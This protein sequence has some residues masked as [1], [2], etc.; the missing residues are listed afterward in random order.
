MASGIKRANR[1][2]EFT[3]EQI[4]EL[5]KCQKDPV[6]FIR[7]YVKV[8]HPTKGGVPFDLY[9]YQ[10]EIIDSVHNNKD[11]IIL[12]SRQLGK[13]VSNHININIAK[14][15]SWFKLLLLYFMDRKIYCIAKSM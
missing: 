1:D 5:A 7:N 6:Y 10:L 3:P 13:C 8:Q 14:K 9:D 4:M 15:P 12:A 2:S 11:S